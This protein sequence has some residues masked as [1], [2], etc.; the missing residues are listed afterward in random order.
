MLD[1]FQGGAPAHLARGDPR[2]AP[3]A[4]IVTDQR[5]RAAALLEYALSTAGNPNADSQNSITA[6][7]RGPVLTQDQKITEHDRRESW[8]QRQTRAPASARSHTQLLPGP[9]ATGGRTS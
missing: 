5:H 6:G 3:P 7:P 2:L 1:I 9:T 8:T 4:A